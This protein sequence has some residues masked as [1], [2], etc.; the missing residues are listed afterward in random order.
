MYKDSVLTGL[1]HILSLTETNLLMLDREVSLFVPRNAQQQQFTEAECGLMYLMVHAVI[2]KFEG[3]MSF[4]KHRRTYACT[5]RN[6]RPFG[7]RSLKFSE[8]NGPLFY[9]GEI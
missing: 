2:I 3:L 4:T 7:V 9:P 6:A 5:R 1:E 8:N